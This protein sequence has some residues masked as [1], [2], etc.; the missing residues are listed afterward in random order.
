MSGLFG[1]ELNPKLW[2]TLETTIKTYMDFHEIRKRNPD[3]AYGWL[4][5]HFASKE[6]LTF[7]GVLEKTA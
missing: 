6:T 4:D 2:M 5:F 3:L 1:R 7:E